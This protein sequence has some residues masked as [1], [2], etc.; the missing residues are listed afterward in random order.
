MIEVTESGEITPAQAEYI[1][2]R[3]REQTEATRLKLPATKGDV[4]RLELMV[5]R[6]GEGVAAIIQALAMEVV[7]SKPTG[8]TWKWPKAE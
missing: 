7:A 8:P 2:G 4:E 3:W 6:I 1:K 5:D